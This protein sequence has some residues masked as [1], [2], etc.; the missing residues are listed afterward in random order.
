VR[1]DPN[2]SAATREAIETS[3]DQRSQGAGV[4]AAS[5]GSLPSGAVRLP[6]RRG[7]ALRTDIQAL[8]AFA[9][10]AVVLYHLWPNRLTGGYIGVDVFF[11]ISGYLIGAHLLRELT[12]SGSVAVGAFWARR[13]KRLLPA[14][15][16]VLA[17]T[18]VAVVVWVPRSLWP[19]FLSEITASTLYV[20]NW[21]LAH[22]A[23]DYLASSNSASPVR[24][25][26]TLSVEEQFYV[27]LP[28]LLLVTAWL[29][30]GRG[31]RMLTW[32]RV[33]IGVAVLASFLYSVWMMSTTPS[34]AYFSTFTRAWEFG[35]GAL[36][37][38]FPIRRRVPWGRF[39]PWIGVAVLGVSCVTFDATTQFP[40]ATALWPVVGTLVALAAGR[41][42]GLARLGSWRPVAF[43]GETSYG[44]YLWHWPLIVLLP[45]V[46]GHAL[47]TL[48]KLA[49]LGATFVLAALSTHLVENPVRFELL[50]TA[51]PRVVGLWTLAAMALVLVVAI[52]PMRLNDAQIAE[53]ADKVAAAEGTDSPCFGA[54]A[55]LDA[56][57]ADAPK[58]AVLVPDP[59]ALD[60]DDSNRPECFTSRSDATLRIC[61]LGPKAYSRHIFAV[62][63]SHNS[64]LIAAYD[65]IA[66]D[67]GWRI[68]VAGRG[69][70]YWTT[71]EQVVDNPSTA[72]ACRSWRRSVGEHV[73]GATDLDAI[74]VTNSRLGPPV[75]DVPGQSA[76]QATADGMVAAWDAR[77]SPGEIPVIAIGDNPEVSAKTIACVEQ[78][79]LEG[80]DVCA[81]PLG[82]ATRAF[83]AQRL[84]TASA[85]NAHFIDTT[86]LY[87][88][89]T[90]CPAVAGGVIVYRDETSHLTATYVRTIA[91]YLGEQIGSLL[92]VEG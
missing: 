16:L 28:L 12:T 68:D 44:A 77:P 56:A 83:D 3:A 27:G 60:S 4:S 37:A 50:R 23:V 51:R 64:T 78:N 24:H 52:V 15:L 82:T 71:A 88:V 87:C 43:L 38:A 42:T 79:G 86:A 26:W 73:G 65:K 20:E 7:E 70:C 53:D 22:D 92:P 61:S 10:L 39:A 48:D 6:G 66:R 41:G 85:V 67:R 31:A 81:I 62:G 76:E 49:I 8:R 29:V 17:T 45:F 13:A 72:D 55:L 21:L 80:A 33:A 36:L 5:S 35:A 75:A 19:Q 30:R 40:G 32:S 58:P 11:V 18:A 14:S 84:A 74:V 46:A 54:G 25:F 91:D 59:A 47:T 9:V 34:V 63:D 57:C 2:R 1:E 90:M 89:Q 69:G